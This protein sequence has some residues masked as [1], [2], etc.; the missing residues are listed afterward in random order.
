M[1]LLF[2]DDNGG[3]QV[4]TL[5]GWVDADFG[6]IHMKR[7]VT[8]ASRGLY[9]LIGGT[10]YDAI[11]AAYE[12]S[13]LTEI[14]E[15]AQAAILLDA[16]RQYV[17]NMDLSHT[18]DGRKMRSDEHS[19]VPMEYM[20]DRSNENLER[21]Y[22][23][24]LDH[25]IELM[26]SEDSGLDAWIASDEYAAMHSTWVA[27]T[28]QLQEFFPD[29]NRLILLKLMPELK[30]IQRNHIKSKLLAATYTTIDTAIKE[31]SAIEDDT[32]QR[33]LDLSRE[34]M[35]YYAI[36]WAFLRL[37]VT[38]FPEGV[39]Q[40]FSSER[41]STRGKAV[42]L[43]TKVQEVSNYYKR[44]AIARAVELDDLL[45]S[46]KPVEKRTYSTGVH[47]NDNDNFISL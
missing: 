41:A 22:F 7:E 9:K 26:E 24:A 47:L 15:T 18:P 36:S 11:H 12:A 3:E 10:T 31:R 23:Q 38:I 16:Y 25:L 30:R 40:F 46:L 35:I 37:Q 34:V 8:L 20:L 21:K 44:D 39:L 27:T 6:F 5:L 29:G 42:P 45:Q 14:V 33:M 2:N 28:A 4:K 32:M 43:G 17:P 13:E 1:D 19:K